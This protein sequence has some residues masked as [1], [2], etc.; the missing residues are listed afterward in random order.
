MYA[1]AIM[2]AVVHG[3]V[4]AGTNAQKSVP[5]YHIMYA[6]VHGGVSASVCVCM[7]CIAGTHSQKSV[8]YYVLLYCY[9]TTTFVFSNVSALLSFLC[10]ITI[11]F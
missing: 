10:T 9:F 6:V 1:I 3:G 2:Y 11:D 5:Y 8:P 7:C 4:I